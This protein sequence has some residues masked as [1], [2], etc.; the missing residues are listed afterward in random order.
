MEENM[1]VMRKIVEINEALCT[2]C[3]LCAPACA[4]GALQIVNGKAKIVAD[5][6]CDGLGACLGECPE[7]ALKIIERESEDFDE[8]AVEERLKELKRQP[9]APQQPTSLP[10]GCP[11]A[12]IEMFAQS[13]PILASCGSSS[14]LTHWPVQIRLIPAIVPFLHKADI[15]VAADCAPIAYPD[16]HQ[17]FIAGKVVMIGCPKFDD[18]EGYYKKFISIFNDAQIKS[19]TSVIMEVPCCKGLAALVKQALLECKKGIPLE[20]VVVSVRGH[21]IHSERSII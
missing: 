16:F 1:K 19:V 11:S 3:G 21:V 18:T 20:E 12:K 4:E 13:L 5:K 14:C 9:H 10:C 8:A 17:H 7:G 2:G 15:L 6:Y